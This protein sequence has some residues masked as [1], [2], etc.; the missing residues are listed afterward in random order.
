MLFFPYISNDSLTAESSATS[1]ELGVGLL[2]HPTPGS[3]IPCCHHVVEFLALVI[4]LSG[5]GLACQLL[6]CLGHLYFIVERQLLLSCSYGWDV[7][8]LKLQADS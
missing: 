6:V 8:C 1:E 2:G 4:W 3:S 7:L 5:N